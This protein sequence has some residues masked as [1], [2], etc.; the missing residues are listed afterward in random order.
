MRTG[1]YF[2]TGTSESHKIF[3]PLFLL[4]YLYILIFM[5]LIEN[6]HIF[7]SIYLY[8]TVFMIVSLYAWIDVKR[9]IFLSVV[10]VSVRRL[11]L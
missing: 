9:I 8:S 3:R 11:F 10:H 4:F 2:V 5:Q 6:F 7:A 1:V